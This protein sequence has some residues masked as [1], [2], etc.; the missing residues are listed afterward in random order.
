MD[1]LATYLRGART[2][3][4]VD[5]VVR[6]FEVVDG[7]P[8]IYIR[9]VGVNGQTLDFYVVGNRLIP[10]AIDGKGVVSLAEALRADCA[11]FAERPRFGWCLKCQAAIHEDLLEAPF[12]VA[13]AGGRS[14][15]TADGPGEAWARGIQTCPNC[16][17]QWEVE[18]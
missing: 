18:A 9:P 3:D 4:A 2:A 12:Y 13:V 1:T 16:G 17:H 6:L 10:A 15:N 5:H 7:C 11:P 8:L 14:P